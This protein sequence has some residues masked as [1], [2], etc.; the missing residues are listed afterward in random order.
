MGNIFIKTEKDRA[1]TACSY[2][3]R[4]DHHIRVKIGPL[5]TL[6]TPWLWAGCWEN[7]IQERPRANPTFKPPAFEP[8]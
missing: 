6:S 1:A 2:I 8:R 5:A 3:F 4:I 7:T